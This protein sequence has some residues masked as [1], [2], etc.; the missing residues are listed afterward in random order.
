VALETIADGVHQ[1]AP[2]P[3]D[4]DLRM[5]HLRDVFKDNEPGIESQSDVHGFQDQRISGILYVSSVLANLSK[6]LAFTVFGHALAWWC[7]EQDI[8]TLLSQFR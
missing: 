2:L 7:G 4:N 3:I 6:D 5:N 8:Q 1:T